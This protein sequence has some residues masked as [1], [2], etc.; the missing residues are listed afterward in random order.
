MIAQMG[1]HTLLIIYAEEIQNFVIIIIIIIIIKIHNFGSPQHILIK[2]YGI[3]F[4][5]AL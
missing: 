5:R 4:T 2:A 3:P 1:S